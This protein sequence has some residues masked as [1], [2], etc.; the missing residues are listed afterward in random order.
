MWISDTLPVTEEFSM[1]IAAPR[2]CYLKSIGIVLFIIIVLRIDFNNLLEPLRHF[3]LKVLLLTV[4]FFFVLLLIKAY[5]WLLLVKTQGISNLNFYK[6]Y[7]VYLE[8]YFAGAVT[9]GRIGEIIKYKYINSL[10]NSFLKSMYSV[11]MDRLS[12]VIILFFVGYIGIFY[13]SSFLKTEII[14]VTTFLFCTLLFAFIVFLKHQWFLNIFTHVVNK[15]TGKKIETMDCDY[16]AMILETK[17][18]NLLLVS[19]FS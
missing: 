3:D 12:D 17:I 5:R 9:P 18:V 16:V 1:K 7:L 10:G 6:M 19:F 14:I 8:S 2:K 4:P 15:F 11:I 13:F